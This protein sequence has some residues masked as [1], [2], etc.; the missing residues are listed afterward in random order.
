V[1]IILRHE[2]YELLRAVAHVLEGNNT[3]HYKHH[4]MQRIAFAATEV[5]IAA[6]ASCWTLGFD[7][8]S[9]EYRGHVSL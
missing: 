5:P 8:A 2:S 7:E 1:C 3:L 4:Q 9:C 6:P